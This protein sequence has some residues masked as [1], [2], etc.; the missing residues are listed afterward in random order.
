MG[1]CRRP[2][3]NRHELSPATPSRWCV[4]QVP[5]LRLEQQYI[6]E[7]H[8]RQEQKQGQNIVMDFQ[9]KEGKPKVIYAALSI[10][11]NYFN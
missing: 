10:K 2:D 1:W 8:D 4:Y 6:C 3:S 5:P 9:P 7:N 11:T